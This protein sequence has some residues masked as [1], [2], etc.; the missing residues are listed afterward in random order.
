MVRP[1]SPV[2]KPRTHIWGAYIVAGTLTN[3]MAPAL[4]KVY[5]QMPEPREHA[6]PS[7]FCDDILLTNCIYRVGHFH[8]FMRKRRRV[9]PLF[10]FGGSRLRPY[11]IRR[12]RTRLSL[13]H[14][15]QVLSPS[16]FTSQVAHQQRRLCSTVSCSS[17]ERCGGTASR[18]CGACSHVQLYSNLTNLTFDLT[19]TAV[20]C[21]VCC[22]PT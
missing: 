2:F 6:E 9:L 13:T 20:N 18:C 16:T 5:D 17:N 22:T 8:G 10:V 14:M 3:K 4:R 7:S 12:R 21:F 1:L 19:G 11:V 15:S